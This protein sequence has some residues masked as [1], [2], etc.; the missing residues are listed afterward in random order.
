MQ[1]RVVVS[2]AFN[3][4]EISA[5]HGA[6]NKAEPGRSCSKGGKIITPPRTRKFPN[7]VAVQKR[8]LLRQQVASTLAAGG[9]EADVR[10]MLMKALAE[11]RFGGA[12]REN[13]KEAA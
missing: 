13:V 9:G 7:E 11:N 2:G 6:S 12:S 1:T 3:F 8:E 10:E 4:H 5:E